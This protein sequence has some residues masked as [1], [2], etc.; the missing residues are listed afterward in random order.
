MKNWKAKK[1]QSKNISIKC[2]RYNIIKEMIK[3]LLNSFF[4]IGVL[5]SKKILFYMVQWKALMKNDENWNNGNW[6]SFHLERS[7]HSQDI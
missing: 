6:F 4:K 5:P 2:I 1:F 3:L 7:L